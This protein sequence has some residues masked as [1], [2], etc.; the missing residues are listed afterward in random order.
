MPRLLD[1]LLDE[2]PVVAERRAR[3]AAGEAEG[4]LQFSLVAGDADAL[5]AAAGSRL[6]HHRKA[7]AL[8]DGD[9]LLGARDLVPMARHRRHASLL[10]RPV[11]EDLVAHQPDH[12]RVGADE[13]DPLVGESLG[14]G[15][16]LGEKAITRVHRVRARPPCR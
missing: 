9:A 3:F 7:D 14:E 10:G 15:R 12:F 1:E 6:Q 4:V 8:G 2:Y 13:G 11:G 5:T 16:P